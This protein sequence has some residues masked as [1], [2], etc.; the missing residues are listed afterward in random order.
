MGL[1]Q[2]LAVTH[3]SHN[4]DS[5]VKPMLTATKLNLVITVKISSWDSASLKSRCWCCLAFKDVL[6]QRVRVFVWS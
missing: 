4:A 5:L 2:C 3:H 1:G 6:C